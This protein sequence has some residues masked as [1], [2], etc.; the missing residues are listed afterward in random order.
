LLTNT[1]RMKNYYTFFFCFVVL[2]FCRLQVFS[3]NTLTLNGFWKCYPVPQDT[4]KTDN[5]IFW[6]AFDGATMQTF[7][8]AGV[9]TPEPAGE[10]TPYE[11]KNNVL[12]T[13]QGKKTLKL[14]VTVYHSNFISYTTPANGKPETVYLKREIKGR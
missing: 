14:N 12:K 11:F 10:K 5:H 7:L 1:K 8:S 2:C 9:S 6:I 3:Q 13:L 4:L